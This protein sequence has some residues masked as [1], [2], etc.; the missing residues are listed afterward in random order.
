MQIEITKRA[1][2]GMDQNER[3]LKTTLSSGG[4]DTS[5]WFF[6][7]LFLRSD[8]SDR[9]LVEGLGVGGGGRDVGVT[10][11]LQNVST[12]QERAEQP[13]VKSD[14][15]VTRGLTHLVGASGELELVG[16]L[17][18]GI[19]G[20]AVGGGVILKVEEKGEHLRKTRSQ[21]SAALREE[22]RMKEKLV[23][24]RV[25]TVRRAKHV[26]CWVFLMLQTQAQRPWR[27]DA[28]AIQV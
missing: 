28:W 8:R 16:S 6:Q 23:Q 12:G 25:Q 5:F 17:Q 2:T 21:K 20:G 13:S 26:A 9:L 27:R 18:V 22:H 11:S 10:G 14:D 15:L 4:S 19:A 7:I 3:I 24:K 1:T